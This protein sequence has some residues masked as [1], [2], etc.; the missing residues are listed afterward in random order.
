MN[1]VGVPSTWPEAGPLSH[2]ALDPLQYGRAG[3]V[4]VEGSYV[5]AELGGV[6]SQ[7]A[8]FERLLAVEQ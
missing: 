7:V 6:A 5:Q 3:P 1:R 4:V 8:V 2:V